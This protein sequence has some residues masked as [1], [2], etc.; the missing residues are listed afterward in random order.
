LKPVESA[1]E[2][3][4]AEDIRLP[5]ADRIQS[6]KGLVRDPLGSIIPGAII[7]VFPKDSIQ[8]AYELELLANQAGEFSFDLPDGT[9]FVVVKAKGFQRSVLGIEVSRA[10][11]ARSLQIALRAPLPTTK[12]HTNDLTHAH[13]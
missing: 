8:K 4:S 3:L 13:A 11:A 9:Y 12:V 1:T 7:W 6:F 2:E 10:G 5:I